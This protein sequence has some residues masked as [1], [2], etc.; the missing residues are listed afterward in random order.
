MG[1]GVGCCIHRRATVLRCTR[2]CVVSFNSHNS[3]DSW[4]GSWGLPLPWWKGSRQLGQK[5]TWSGLH[6]AQQVNFAVW[7]CSSTR[8][9]RTTWWL[10]WACLVFT[11]SLHCTWLHC[12]FLQPCQF[13]AWAVSS[14]VARWAQHM[15]PVRQSQAVWARGSPPRPCVDGVVHRIIIG[16]VVWGGHPGYSPWSQAVGGNTTSVLPSHQVWHCSPPQWVTLLIIG[17]WLPCWEAS[18]TPEGAFVCGW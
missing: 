2:T 10:V 12:H 3:H 8:R 18:F 15:Q 13:R 5:Q 7:N 14:L 17:K 16:Y 9:F 1:T 11:L 6:S 4:D